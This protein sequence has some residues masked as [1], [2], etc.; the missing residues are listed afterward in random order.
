M[1]F[2]NIDLSQENPFLSEWII[3]KTHVSRDVSDGKSIASS[4]MLSSV[5]SSKSKRFNI[6]G[7][8]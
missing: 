6:D 8:L 4:Y 1:K 3:R 2:I 5:L 7:I